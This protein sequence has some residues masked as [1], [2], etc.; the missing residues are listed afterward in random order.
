MTSGITADGEFDFKI[1]MN[2]DTEVT[3]SPHDV[4][5]HDRQVDNLINS[6]ADDVDLEDD[7]AIDL[8]IEDEDRS[9]DNDMVSLINLKIITSSSLI[10]VDNLNEVDKTFGVQQSSV[11]VSLVSL[12]SVNALYHVYGKILNWARNMDMSV[13]RVRSI[14]YRILVYQTAEKYG[15]ETIFLSGTN[16]G[17]KEGNEESLPTKKTQFTIQ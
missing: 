1:M 9:S 4:I 7:V 3:T 6:H 16:S 8:E 10:D 13:L 15:L 14:F 17:L 5:E 2:D 12:T 11:E